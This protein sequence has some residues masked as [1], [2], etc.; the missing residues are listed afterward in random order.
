MTYK[1]NTHLTEH[2]PTSF[3]MPY[4]K[5]ACV[6]CIPVTLFYL[7]KVFSIL[8][9]YI[10][11]SVFKVLCWQFERGMKKTEVNGNEIQRQGDAEIFSSRCLPS[12][13]LDDGLAYIWK[14]DCCFLIRQW[15]R[16]SLNAASEKGILEIWTTTSI[17]WIL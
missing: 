11:L 7:P 2:T 6:S 17:W 15:Q 9:A 4:T 16:I 3:F 12:P 10:C 5:L 14:M 13:G 1:Q 8:F